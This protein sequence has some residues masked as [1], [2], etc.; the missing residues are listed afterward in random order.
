MLVF[1]D[2][3]GINVN[4]EIIDIINCLGEEYVCI[5]EEGT[6]EEDGFVILK[7]VYVDGDRITSGYV[8][9]QY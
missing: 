1:T 7:T 5:L 2:N 9:K 8:M 6:K 4:F 3:D